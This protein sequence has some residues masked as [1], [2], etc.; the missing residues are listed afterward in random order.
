MTPRELAYRVGEK[1]SCELE[2]LGVLWPRTD[3]R[4]A[5][6]DVSRFYRSIR[7]APAQ[8]FAEPGVVCIK[9]C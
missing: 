8:F 5:A 9:Q 7:Q 6:W 1:A 4:A 3:V 2:R